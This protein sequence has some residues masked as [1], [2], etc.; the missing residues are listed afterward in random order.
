MVVNDM[1]SPVFA[2]TPFLGNITRFFEPGAVFQVLSRPLDAVLK[3]SS[4]PIDTILRLFE[5]ASRSALGSFT[6][7]YDIYP[8]S[9]ATCM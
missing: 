4:R 9:F 6:K 1:W 8:N 2:L 5:V 7:K 3:I